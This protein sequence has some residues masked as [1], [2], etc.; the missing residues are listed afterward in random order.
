MHRLSFIY[1]TYG[2]L[3]SPYARRPIPT[4]TVR[5]GPDLLCFVLYFLK[6]LR[7]RSCKKEIQ[8]V[9][10]LKTHYTG[11]D[12]VGSILN[13]FAD[14]R[15][16]R[17]ALPSGGLSTFYWPSRFHWKYVDIMLLDGTLP[18]ILCNHARFNG[19]VMDEIMQ[20]QTAFIT[21]LRDPVS[22]FEVTFQNLN[23]AEI[24]E[25]EDL[26]QPYLTFLENP[27]KY[28]GRAIQRKRFK[29]GECYCFWTFGRLPSNVLSKHVNV[30]SQLVKSTE[31]AP[32]FLEFLHFIKKTQTISV[33]E[34]LQIF[35]HFISRLTEFFFECGP[36]RLN[37]DSFS[38][39]MIPQRTTDVSCKS[40]VNNTVLN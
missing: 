3:D 29:V 26:P 12:V 18:N 11:S 25:M 15:G 21:I 37:I 1:Q 17:I 6:L 28:I 40:L 19:E 9:L 2:C 36:A 5:A 32:A 24:L 8:N 35:R 27:G 20:P 7:I 39:S 30:Q 23:F 22:H 38:R 34:K 31:M 16:L 10:L 4:R 33:C 13:R 14:L